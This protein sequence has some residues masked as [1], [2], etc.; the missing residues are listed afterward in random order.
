MAG[1]LAA[2]GTAGMGGFLCRELGG[3]AVGAEFYVLWVAGRVVIQKVPSGVP[4]GMS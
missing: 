1:C 2:P 4:T 3:E